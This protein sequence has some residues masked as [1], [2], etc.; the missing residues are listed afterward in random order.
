MGLSLSDNG[1]KRRFKFERYSSSKNCILS[2]NSQT[3]DF[4]HSKDAVL[5][6]RDQRDFWDSEECSCGELRIIKVAGMISKST[7]FDRNEL[8]ANL[9]WYFLHLSKVLVN[10]VLK[11]FS[12][13]SCDT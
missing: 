11:A 8:R 13:K 9:S 12:F 1:N 7:H 5:A 2:S 3:V 6:P 10:C 4:S